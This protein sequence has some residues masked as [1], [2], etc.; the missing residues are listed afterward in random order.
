MLWQVNILIPFYSNELNPG[1]DENDL[2]MLYD[3]NSGNFNPKLL[4]R[5]KS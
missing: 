2:F 4:Y 5:K 3:V 1:N